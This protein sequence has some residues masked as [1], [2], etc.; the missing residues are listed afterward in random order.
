MRPWM[1]RAIRLIMNQ[2][3]WNTVINLK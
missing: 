1:P 2:I 3:A